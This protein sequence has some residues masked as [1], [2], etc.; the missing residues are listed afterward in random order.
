MKLY[1]YESYQEYVDAQVAAN[2]RKINNVWVR[3]STISKIKAAAGGNVQTILCHGTRNAAEQK[4]FREAYPFAMIVGT[5]ISHTADQFPMTVQW[6]FHEEKEGWNNRFDLIY[7]NSFDHS[8]DPDKCLTTW[9]GQLAAGGKLFLEHALDESDN[10]SRVSDPLEISTEEVV[11]LLE[12]KGLRII[13][14]L[15][16]NDFKNHPSVIFVCEKL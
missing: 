1:K 7:S 8:Y 13:T 12:S 6:D 14:R 4:Y 5:E 10:R 3:P 16:Q 2:V 15:Q 11:E 9:V